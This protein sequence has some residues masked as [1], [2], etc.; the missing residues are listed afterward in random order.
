MSLVDHVARVHNNPCTVTPPDPG[1]GAVPTETFA[2]HPMQTGHLIYQCGG[3]DKRT[4][5]KFEKVRTLL[6]LSKLPV[7]FP[8][9]PNELCLFFTV[10]ASAPPRKIF[11]GQRAKWGKSHLYPATATCQCTAARQSSLAGLRKKKQ[12]AVVTKKIT[13]ITNNHIGGRRAR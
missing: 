12:Q 7:F 2:N 4:I 6:P 5:E 8:P 13:L 3:I 9:S 1:R 11:P 10:V